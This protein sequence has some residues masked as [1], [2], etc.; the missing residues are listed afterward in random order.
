MPRPIEFNMRDPVPFEK[1]HFNSENKTISAEFMSKT[2]QLH[3]LYKERLNKEG[4]SPTIKSGEVNYD[5]LAYQYAS[6][7]MPGDW[8]GWTDDRSTTVGPST[9]TKVEVT[10]GFNDPDYILPATGK[11]VGKPA[12]QI[13]AG[14]EAVN[15][16]QH[17]KST[18][19]Y[20][21]LD[22]NQPY[23]EWLA[24]AAGGG[25]EIF[26]ALKSAHETTSAILS[27]FDS[28]CLRLADERISKYELGERVKVTN[29]NLLIPAKVP[30]L[31]RLQRS[32]KG[33][34]LLNAMDACISSKIL[35]KKPYYNNVGD[36]LPKGAFDK[37]ALSGLLDYVM[38]QR[39]ASIV[40]RNTF[41]H[42]SNADGAKGI[43][44]AIRAG[45][46]DE[47]WLSSGIPGFPLMRYRTDDQ[48]AEIF[49]IA[50]NRGAD[51]ARVDFFPAGNNGYL[52]GEAFKEK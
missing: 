4:K 6:E 24:F 39:T 41:A 13:L 37:V 15:S 35:G 32:Y 20:L 21:L 48:I 40:T 18:V 49:E 29:R 12:F 7:L 27:D 1:P 38:T 16:L 10:Y 46:P 47:E 26:D 2:L 30:F 19:E 14:A 8:R 50:N 22:N 42:V 28:D 3:R 51:I 44:T 45:H 17:R 5:D 11:P 33:A 31:D 36:K 52:V 34:F 25:I 23:E 43:Y 9:A